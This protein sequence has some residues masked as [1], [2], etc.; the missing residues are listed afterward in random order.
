MRKLAYYGSGLGARLGPVMSVVEDR[1]R[2]N[3]WAHGG[4]K[5]QPSLPEVDAFHFAP[6]VRIPT[7]LLGGRYDFEYPVELSQVP[8]FR[9]LG[10]PA[11]QK[12]HVVFETGN[13]PKARIDLTVD[14][15]DRYLGPVR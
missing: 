12:R 10:A 2:A 9:A 11:D 14:W 3:V 4:L 1:F 15:L 7:L 5:P 8:L 13:V 6:R